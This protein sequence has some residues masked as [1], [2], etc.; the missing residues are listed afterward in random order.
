MQYPGSQV[1]LGPQGPRRAARPGQAELTTNHLLGAALLGAGTQR[2]DRRVPGSSIEPPS[3]SQGSCQACP[4]ED[5]GA[6]KA[7]GSG[8][9]IAPQGPFG[10][11]RNLEEV[12]RQMSSVLCRAHP[13]PSPQVPGRHA[14]CAACSQLKTARGDSHSTV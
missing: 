9:D 2:C 14:H 13:A 11:R 1:S 6:G 5:I 4:A 12:R 10:P 7:G 8:E 3:V